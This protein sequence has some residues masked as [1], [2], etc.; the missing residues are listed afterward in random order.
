MRCIT[1]ATIRTVPLHQDLFS[2]LQ[3]Q[4]DAYDVCIGLQQLTYSPRLLTKDASVSSFSC[5]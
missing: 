1:V 3:V 4:V 2:R 5:V